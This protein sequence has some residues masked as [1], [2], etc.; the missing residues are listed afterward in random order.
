VIEKEIT[1][2][3]PKGL[4]S[5]PAALVARTLSKY[6]SRVTLANDGME[7]DA[8]NIMGVLTLCAPHGSRLTLRAHGEDESDALAAVEGALGEEFESSYPS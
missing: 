4:H 8:R 2:R 6:H 1:I 3:N 7:I 5:R